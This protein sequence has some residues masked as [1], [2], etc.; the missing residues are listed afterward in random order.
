NH[1]T[2]FLNFSA[3]LAAPSV[4]TTPA[5]GHPSSRGGES[6][7]AAGRPPFCRFG[8]LVSSCASASA[9]HRSWA[10]D[11][12]ALWSSYRPSPDHR[13]PRRWTGRSA[14]CVSG[15]ARGLCP[16]RRLNRD[17]REVRVRV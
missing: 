13:D 12:Q 10:H 4:L 17:L 14:T 15:W 5:F 6:K 2:A 3:P 7:K 9:D 16:S 8:S 1:N 11:L